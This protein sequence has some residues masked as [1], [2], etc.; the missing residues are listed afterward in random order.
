MIAGYIVGVC[1]VSKSIIKMVDFHQH[2]L[3]HYRRR[4][5]TDL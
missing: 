3:C 2:V 1:E 4:D 5:V